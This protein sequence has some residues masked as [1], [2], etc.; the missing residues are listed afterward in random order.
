MNQVNGHAEEIV[1]QPKEEPGDKF[2]SEADLL[3]LELSQTKLQLAAEILK[4][5]KLED[6][7][8]EAST[9]LQQSQLSVQMSNLTVQRLSR[10][11]DRFEPQGKAARED[12]AKTGEKHEALKKELGGRYEVDMAKAAYDENTGRISLI[13][14][15]PK[16]N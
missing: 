9:A 7:L 14:D 10:K 1:E 6:Q 8:D 12:Y 2:L 13:P 4:S 16:E 5:K 15:A 11:T 3:R